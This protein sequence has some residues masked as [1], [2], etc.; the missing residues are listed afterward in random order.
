MPTRDRERKDVRRRWREVSSPRVRP[1]CETTRRFAL[2]LTACLVAVFVAC[3]EPPPPRQASNAFLERRK[4]ASKMVEVAELAHSREDIEKEAAA[5]RLLIDLWPD[6]PEGKTGG[7]WHDAA[8]RA[9][10]AEQYHRSLTSTRRKGE[11]IEDRLRV[12]QDRLEGMK[13]EL[14]KVLDSS[15]A[16][17]KSR[18]DIIAPAV[19]GFMAGTCVGRQ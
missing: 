7:A 15:A 5:Y 13:G 16:P 19:F 14:G 1:L 18:L 2:L 17:P 12:S 10:K 3:Q 11:A 6:L 8:R 4:M 9:E